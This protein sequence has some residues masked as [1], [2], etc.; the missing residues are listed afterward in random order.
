MPKEKTIDVSFHRHRSAK[1][2]VY[3]WYNLKKDTCTDVDLKQFTG[4]KEHGS[5]KIATD[6][7]LKKHIWGFYRSSEV[8]FW[9][10]KTCDINQIMNLMSHEIA[11]SAGYKSE[12]SAMKVAAISTFTLHVLSIYCKDKIKV[13]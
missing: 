13:M 8:H 9:Y 1:S 10:D 5:I 11:H 4:N 3:A 7:I 12:N 2:L 6:I